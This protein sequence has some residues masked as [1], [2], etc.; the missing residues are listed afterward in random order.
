MSENLFSHEQ[1]STRPRFKNE[2]RVSSY[3]KTF[4]R[5]QHSEHCV[6]TSL[7]SPSPSPPPISKTRLDTTR[8]VINYNIFSHTRHGTLRCH[9][10]PIPLLMVHLNSMFRTAVC[11]SQMRAV[12]NFR[13]AHISKN[14]APITG[15][16]MAPLYPTPWVHSINSRSYCTQMLRL[17]FKHSPVCAARISDISQAC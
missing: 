6:A 4:F 7:P 2:G 9:K 10:R 17:N 1:L 15:R 14:I 8:T 12:R 16:N 11:C 5:T 3:S 13:C